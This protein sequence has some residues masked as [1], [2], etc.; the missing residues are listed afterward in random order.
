[1]A[2][3]GCTSFSRSSNENSLTYHLAITYDILLH[4]RQRDTMPMVLYGTY[5]E[6]RRDNYVYGRCYACQMSN[7]AL[8]GCS[9]K[10]IPTALLCNA[11]ISVPISCT[12]ELATAAVGK[13]PFTLIGS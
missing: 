11:G 7:L 5:P 2:R 3:L 6:A 9:S 4:L 10:K 12:N 8:Y 1:M 13:L